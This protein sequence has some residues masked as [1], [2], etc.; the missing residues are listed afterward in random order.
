MMIC[1][2]T[3]VYQHLLLLLLPLCMG[4]AAM[5]GNFFPV[6]RLHFAPVNEQQCDVCRAR[7][8]QP[9]ADSEGQR[10]VQNDNLPPVLHETAAPAA[11]RAD[12]EVTAVAWEAAS[13][14]QVVQ[15]AAQVAPAP[16]MFFP[17]APVIPHVTGPISVL[18]P[19]PEC[20]PC[21]ESTPKPC[22][23]PA[24]HTQQIDA[25]MKRVNRM[26]TALQQ[27]NASILRLQ[28]SL[29]LANREVKRLKAEVQRWQ[30]E[31]QRL[32]SAMLEQHE[33]DIHSLTRITEMLGNLMNPEVTAVETRGVK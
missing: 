12:L 31:V 3:P 20:G 18:Q 28:E 30:G 23:P 22:P 33:T 11:D 29:T 13:N 5:P 14:D 2:K 15:T 19:V 4:C 26:E 24:A 7:A 17:P 27:S 1:S 10:F 32:E 6:S 21:V 8:Q 9:S 16:L 25:L